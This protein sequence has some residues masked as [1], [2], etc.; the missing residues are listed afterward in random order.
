MSKKVENTPDGLE[1]VEDVLS[2]TEQYIE[3][4]QK[5]LLITVGSIVGI[6]ILYLVFQN[7]H[8]KPLQEE[9]VASMYGAEQY[10]E[11]DSFNLA[12]DGDGNHIGFLDIIEEYG[13]TKA[14]NLAN[15]YAGISY[16]RTGDY[17]TAIDYLKDFNAVSEMLTP[18]T[19]GAIGDAYAEM[20]D[21]EEALSYYLSAADHDNNFTAPIYLMKAAYIYEDLDNYEGALEAYERIENDYP[22]S[23]EARK[24][25]KYIARAKFKLNK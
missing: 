11:K 25:E 14:G 18:V 15:Y 22:K 2:R 4:N 10:F 7:M 8:I 16:L 13:S 21:L 20:E 1:A 24:V 23:T 12:L 17:E 3:K 5:T 9:A 19:N 6:V